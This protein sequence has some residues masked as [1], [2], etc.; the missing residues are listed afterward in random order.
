[1]TP[2]WGAVTVGGL[3]GLAGGAVASVPLV[4]LGVADTD[5]AGGQ[6][7]LILVG[8]AA[9]LLAG[10]VAGRLAGRAEPING[11][12][13]ALSLF[14][15]VALISLAAGADP[16]LATLAFSGAVALVLGSAGGVLAAARRSE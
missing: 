13:A 15:V 7:V 3:S 12:M 1:M 9:Q 8:L 16:P 2:N 11:G 5:S 4:V 14:L 10:F 6:A